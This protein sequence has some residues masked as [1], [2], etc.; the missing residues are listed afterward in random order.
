MSAS[1]TVDTTREDTG[2]LIVVAS[3]EVDLSNIEAFR[4]TL[5][6]AAD[7]NA[8]S[9]TIDL[10]QVEYVDSAGINV[11]FTLSERIS[12]VIANPV[13]MTTFAVSGLAE[14]VPVERAEL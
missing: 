10:S 8:G 5:T 7:N 6:A 3:G 12:K 14:L 4:R 13:L 11:L 2:D 9:L 1:L